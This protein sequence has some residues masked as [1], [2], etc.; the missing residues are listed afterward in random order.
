MPQRSQVTKALRFF[1]K[2][3]TVPA[4]GVKFIAKKLQETEEEEGETQRYLK[5]AYTYLERQRYPNKRMLRNIKRLSG[6]FNASD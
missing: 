2:N 4:K 1:H 5:S 3:P 6:A